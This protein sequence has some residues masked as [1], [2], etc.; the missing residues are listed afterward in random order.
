MVVLL[1]SMQFLFIFSSGLPAGAFL[2]EKPAQDKIEV[3]SFG[4]LFTVVLDSTVQSMRKIAELAGLVQ[5]TQKPLSQPQ[6]QKESSQSPLGLTP[7]QNQFNQSV[8]TTGKFLHSFAPLATHSVSMNVLY[9][10]KLILFII[11]SSIF[12]L[13]YRL[14]V[15]YT[16]ALMSI[17]RKIS[18]LLCKLNPDLRISNQGFFLPNF[19]PISLSFVIPEQKNLSSRT[20]HI[21]ISTNKVRRDLKDSP[22]GHVIPLHPLNLNQ[23]WKQKHSYINIDNLICVISPKKSVQS[24]IMNIIPG[25]LK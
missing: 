5:S 21:V 8:K 20:P 12:M 4:G 23:F 19:V 16:Q 15:Y 13:L 18:L 10:N 1:L 7:V 11:L 14:K 25:E 17:D 22:G 2:F 3:I 6:K 24:G 9:T